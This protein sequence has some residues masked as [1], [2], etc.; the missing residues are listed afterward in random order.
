MAVR[1]EMEGRWA[2]CRIGRLGKI[3]SVAPGGFLGRG[4]DGSSW[5]SI[6]PSFLSVADGEHLDSVV[7]KAWMYDDLCK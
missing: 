6:R 2:L 1:H 7:E 4:L 3:T 5:V